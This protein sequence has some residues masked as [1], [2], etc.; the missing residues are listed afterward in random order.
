[1]TDTA[2]PPKSSPENV[3][4]YF[5]MTVGKQPAGRIV[6]EV[7]VQQLILTTQLYSDL[8]PKTC[9]NFRALC[10]GEKTLT[11]KSSIL[12]RVLLSGS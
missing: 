10:T 7:L 6:C 2:L 5:D 4:V 3:H 8:V 11:Y 9:E 12:H 1:M